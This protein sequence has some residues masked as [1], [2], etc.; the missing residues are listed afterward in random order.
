MPLDA[1]YGKKTVA[2]SRQCYP[3]PA[4]GQTPEKNFSF[5][6]QHFQ[7]V[8]IN[9][10]KTLKKE[11]Q[12]ACTSGKRCYFCT[13]N[14]GEVLKVLKAGSEIK[15]DQKFFIRKLA[16]NKISFYLCTPQYGE[17]IERLAGGFGR[18]GDVKISKKNFKK[19]LQD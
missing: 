5:Q 12:K 17:F 18:K 16:R 14:N 13:R 2:I 19:S 8:A 6:R 3:S 11:E 9:I 7:R 15:K 4:I 1:L 10:N